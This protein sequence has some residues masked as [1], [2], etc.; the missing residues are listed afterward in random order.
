LA[1]KGLIVTAM[2]LDGDKASMAALVEIIILHP[3][4]TRPFIVV[5]CHY[6]HPKP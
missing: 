1:Y 5:L 4:Y 6:L 2:S 3:R